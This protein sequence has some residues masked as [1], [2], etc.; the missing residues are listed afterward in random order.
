[1]GRRT[2]AIRFAQAVNCLQS[3]GDGVPCLDCTACGQ[4][5]RLVHPDLT[6]VKPERIGGSLKVD[7]VR[8]L[9]YGLHLASY[10]ATFRIALLL[11]F[12]N[13]TDNAANALLTTLEEPL[14]NV[15]I[16]IIAESA[17]S[18]LPTVV[19]R[20]EVIRLRPVPPEIMVQGL[21][22]QWYIPAGEANLLTHISGGRP[23]YSFRLYQNPELLIQRNGWL[24]DL[25]SLL[26]ASRVERFDY[27]DKLAK[28]RDNIYPLL[29]TWLGFWRDVMLRSIDSRSQIT[30]I[31]YQDS[32]NK[33]AHNIDENKIFQIVIGSEAIFDHLDHNV[34]PRLALEDLMLVF[35]FNPN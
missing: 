15:I 22:S 13:A 35:P 24:E 18:L 6:V 5:E 3:T 4:I 34:K 9:Q 7:Q 33:L 19:S 27:A 17:E 8:N 30:N 32:I 25:N 23:G 12:E 29:K 26:L 31:D 10:N 1:V 11:D 16:L 14:Q 28:N 2:L 21:Q 20:C